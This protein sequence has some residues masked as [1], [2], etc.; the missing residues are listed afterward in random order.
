MVRIPS[1]KDDDRVA[2]REL[3]RGGTADEH[4]S[5]WANLKTASD[6]NNIWL[7]PQLE[8]KKKSGQ[9]RFSS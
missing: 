8:P 2:N 7:L 5:T 1:H 6:I 3:L 4:S 9:R